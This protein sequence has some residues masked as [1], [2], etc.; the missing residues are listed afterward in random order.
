MD[1]TD[2]ARSLLIETDGSS[3]MEHLSSASDNIGIGN[4]TFSALTSGASW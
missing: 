1:A 3:L 4:G 2:F